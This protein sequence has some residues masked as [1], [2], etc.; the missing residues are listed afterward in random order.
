MKRLLFVG[1]VVGKAGCDFFSSKLRLI[2]RQFGVDI[3]VVNGE[4]S[5]QGNGITAASADMLL[6]AGAD[7][8]TTG[9]HSFRR[10]ESLGIYERDCIIRPANYPDGGAPGRGVFI[11]HC[12]AYSAAVVNLM[13]TA[14]MDPLDNPFTAIDAILADISTPN[15]FVDFHA[16]ST[17]EKKAMGFYLDG[18]VTG[19]FGTHTHVQAGRLIS[20]MPA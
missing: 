20:P 4:N 1:D 6:D 13:G 16:E 9:N 7:I 18:R 15:I 14:F 19:V 5:A 17:S 11:L 10:K 2:K 3:T 12:G 8:I